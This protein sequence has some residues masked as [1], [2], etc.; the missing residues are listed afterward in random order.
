MLP[1]SLEE[2]VT[3]RTWRYSGISAL[4]PR[5]MEQQDKVDVACG[6][7]DSECNVGKET[8]AQ[9]SLVLASEDVGDVMAEAAVVPPESRP[10]EK[11]AFL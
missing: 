1:F 4:H 11:P 2:A 9:W 7:S 6:P 10:G 5:T 8:G 3:L